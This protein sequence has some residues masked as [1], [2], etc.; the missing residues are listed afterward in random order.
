MYLTTAEQQKAYS[1]KKL[2]EL[3]KRWNDMEARHAEE[4]R[5]LKS[6]IERHEAILNSEVSYE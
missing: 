6:K 3:Y 4:K 1:E 5:V 2:P